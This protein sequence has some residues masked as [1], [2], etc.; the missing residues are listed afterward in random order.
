MGGGGAIRNGV[1][2]GVVAWVD[3]GRKPIPPNSYPLRHGFIA[4]F[5]CCD[6]ASGVG[7]WLVRLRSVFWCFALGAAWGECG[8]GRQGTGRPVFAGIPYRFH[9]NISEP[10]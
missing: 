6:Q 8:S 4:L 9:F 1:G 7:V 10:G 5:A 2:V 3:R